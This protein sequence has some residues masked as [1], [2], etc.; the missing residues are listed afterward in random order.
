MISHK[1]D[2]CIDVV[3]ITYNHE[4]HIKKAIEGVLMQD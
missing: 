2:I 3:M 1:A 4:K